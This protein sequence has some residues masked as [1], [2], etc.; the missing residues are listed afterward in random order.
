MFAKPWSVQKA[1]S[2][3]LAIC[4]V[5][6]AGESRDAVAGVYPAA[7]IARFTCAFLDAASSKHQASCAVRT[8]V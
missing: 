4:H 2:Y 1:N 3:Q 6:F 8:P 5:K 7:E